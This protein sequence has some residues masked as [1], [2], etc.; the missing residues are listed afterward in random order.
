[1]GATRGTGRG[2]GTFLRIRRLG[3]RIP[4][5]ALETSRS[6]VITRPGP[7]CSRQPRCQG[8]SQADRSCPTG[9]T[10]V[11]AFYDESATAGSVDAARS[12]P[13][14]DAGGRGVRATLSRR[15]GTLSLAVR[16]AFWDTERRGPR[17]RI[18]DSGC[19]SPGILRLATDHLSANSGRL[20][21]RLSVD[22]SRVLLRTR[23]RHGALL[24]QLDRLC[25]T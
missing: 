9:A 11:E 23:G 18:A 16:R 24:Q 1:M 10:S 21:P 12:G 7:C 25:L 22:A 19:T 14:L 3:V 17:A 2:G 5:S 8:G 4:P 6:A 15:T 20:D 13:P